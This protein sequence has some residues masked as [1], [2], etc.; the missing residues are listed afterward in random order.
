[1]GTMKARHIGVAEQP[2][3]QLATRYGV[4]LRA[5]SHTEDLLL[6]TSSNCMRINT[7][8]LSN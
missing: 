7:M 1:M 4:L 2:L 8:N 3:P 5:S 6:L